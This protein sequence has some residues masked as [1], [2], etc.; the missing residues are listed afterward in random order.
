M[1]DVGAVVVVAVDF[2][3]GVDGGA[4]VGCSCCLV[5]LIGEVCG[6]RGVFSIDS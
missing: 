3:R 6:R 2:W 4:G 5:M 1:V